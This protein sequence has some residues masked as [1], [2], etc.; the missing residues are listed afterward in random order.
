[1]T[2]PPL[3]GGIRDR[4][5]DLATEDASETLQATRNLAAQRG[6]TSWKQKQGK[7][8]SRGLL[9]V[10]SGTPTQTQ[11]SGL[12]PAEAHHPCPF[13]TQALKELRSLKCSSYNAC[14]CCN[15]Q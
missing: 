4:G 9:W 1:M 7:Q 14:R 2:P 6:N 15:L 11:K 12:T 13:F 3:P 5:G 8:I 10:C